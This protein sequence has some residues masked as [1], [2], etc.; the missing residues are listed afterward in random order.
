MFGIV[1]NDPD[2][3]PPWSMALPPGIKRG[4]NPKDRVG[5][6]KPD[7]SLIPPSALIEMARVMGLGAAKYGPYNWRDSA[8]RMRVYIAAA[9][10]HLAAVLDGEDRDPE[11]KAPH[12]AHAAACMAIIMDA[13]ATGNL[14]D[15]R[16][17]AGAAARLLGEHPGAQGEL[18]AK[19]QAFV[20]GEPEPATRQDQDC[21]AAIFREQG[22]AAL[23][24]A[25]NADA[26]PDINRDPLPFWQNQGTPTPAAAGRPFLWYLATP[27]A[28]CP[29]GIEVAY[30]R[31]VRAA[32]E[33]RARGVHVFCPIEH[34]HQ[35]A[36][37]MRRGSRAVSFDAMGDKLNHDFWMAVDRLFMDRCDGL[38]VMRQPGWDK[39][40][41]VR[42][43]IETFRRASKVI[44]YHDDPVFS[45]VGTLPLQ[46]RWE[47]IV[48]SLR[49]AIGAAS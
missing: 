28:A 19:L 47:G 12:A 40:T 2:T 8:V 16:P 39:S 9:Q 27:Y 30:D 14:V 17:P 20:N 45:Y 32:A 34:N 29:H 48:A 43:E 7:L 31:A 26:I 15:D 10:R 5:G 25:G 46:R 1:P 44:V 41:R 21:V 33:L 35:S 6:T 42:E 11:S 22:V 37:L 13:A 36:M 38:L 23:R 4:E 49:L 3:T 18:E 24:F